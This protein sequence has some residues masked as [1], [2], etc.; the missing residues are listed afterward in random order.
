MRPG[1]AAQAFSH[2]IYLRII[3][4]SDLLRTRVPNS[5]CVSAG[6]R[7][8]VHSRILGNPRDCERNWQGFSMCRIRFLHSTPQTLRTARSRRSQRLSQREPH[9]HR[10]SLLGFNSTWGNPCPLVKRVGHGCGPRSVNARSPRI[11]AL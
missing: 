1:S 7:S 8:G 2:C 9:R 10:N 3:T 11:A 5:G 6:N 4:V